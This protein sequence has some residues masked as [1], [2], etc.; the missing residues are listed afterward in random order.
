M[1]HPE[2]NG[3]VPVQSSQH[4]EDIGEG[5]ERH[6][7][8]A[9][10]ATQ[11][12]ISVEERILTSP[13][14]GEPVIKTAPAREAYHAFRE[15]LSEGICGFTVRGQPE[16]GLAETLR[17]IRQYLNQDYPHL[18]VY[19]H[20]VSRCSSRTRAEV[21][22]GFLNSVGHGILCG[23]NR[24]KMTRL[25][26]MQEEKALASGSPFSIWM[27]HNAESLN[28][29]TCKTLLDMRDLLAS[30]GIRLL[31]I[32]GD[33]V[34]GFTRRILTLARRLN[35]TELSTLFGRAHALRSLCGLQEYT[36]VLMEIDALIISQKSAVTWTEALL[37][38][39]YKEGFR[40][41]SEAP[42][43]HT[44]ILSAS[45][46]GDFPHRALFD[47][48][49]RVMSMSAPHDS[50]DFNIPHGIWAQAASMVMRMDS[51]YLRCDSGSQVLAHE[52]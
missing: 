52:M 45:P 12:G 13:L 36:E 16:N 25:L 32:H 39:A 14:F 42:A 41:A 38:Q 28:L 2:N 7:G 46:C 8:E 17:V 29:E 30:K 35:Q 31:F 20:V 23:S 24:D 27:I 26:N 22:S 37:P 15:I 3:G 51:S 1:R 49:R 21:L 40:L 18:T 33:H 47:V 6:E 44:A 34:E 9:A 50:R 43:L 10:D 48:I 4:D 11:D 19:E 5:G